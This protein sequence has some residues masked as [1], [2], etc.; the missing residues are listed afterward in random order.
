MLP[1]SDLL[2]VA[3]NRVTG[4]ELRSQ[5]PGRFGAAGDGAPVVVW[6]VCMHCNMT[7]PHCYAAAVSKPSPTDLSREEALRLLDELAD[8]GVTVVIFSGGEPLMRP[9]LFDLLARAHELGISPQLS[10]NGVLIDSAVARRLAAVGVAYVGVS[11]DGLAPFNDEYR[12]FTGGADAAF[13]G[14]RCAKQAG[15]RTGL[16]MTLTRRN[17]EQVLA[18]AEVTRNAGADRFYVS[19]LLYSGRGF[20]VAG[21]DL[22]R[23]EARAALEELFARA[24][25]YLVAGEGPRVV[26]GSNDSDGVFLLRWIREHYGDEAAES[27]YQL[28]LE[29]GGNSAGERIVNIDSRGRVHPDQFWRSAVL[30]DVREQSFAAIL[31]HPLREQLRRRLDLLQGRCGVCSQRELCRGSHRERALACFRDPW[32]SDPACVMEDAEIGIESEAAR[33]PAREIA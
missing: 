14:L 31:Q 27:V 30:G 5:A 23:A 2:E 28:L 33:L 4:A 10:T 7:C 32:A 25:A 29:R 20:Q 13:R 19:H 16:R 3:R 24:E 9:D 15:M 8:C 26:T 6:N 17:L 22:S 1:V 12:G 11:I 18:M 21:D